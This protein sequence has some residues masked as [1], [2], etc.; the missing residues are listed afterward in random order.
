M[1]KL[2]Q[3][4]NSFSSILS[5]IK[6]HQICRVISSFF[7]EVSAEQ[8]VCERQGRCALGY[9]PSARH[10]FSKKINDIIKD[11]NKAKQFEVKALS[12]VYDIEPLSSNNNNNTNTLNYKIYYTDY[13]AR[14]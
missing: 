2:F 7:K 8:S 14:E 9:I 6:T 10:T 12:E 11:P 4:K 13:S 3:N 5:S 1:R